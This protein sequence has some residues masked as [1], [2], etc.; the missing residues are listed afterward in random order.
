M[1]LFAFP[2]FGQEL[3]IWNKSAADEVRNRE[4]AIMQANNL[5]FEGD[6]FFQ[7]G[8]KGAAVKAYRQA[9]SLIPPGPRS[10]G[11]RDATT[12]RFAEAATGQAADL[13]KA[14]QQ[15][16]ARSLVTEVLDPSIAPTNKT[17]KKLRE[18]LGDIEF[19]N[20]LDDEAHK[21]AVGKVSRLLQEGHDYLSIGNYDMATLRFSE[22]LGLDRTNTAARKGL[23]LTAKQMAAYQDA[24]YDQ[25]RA[26]AMRGVAEGWATPDPNRRAPNLSRPDDGGLLSS[27]TGS[28]SISRKL[29]TITIPEFSVVNVTIRDVVNLMTQNALEY[30]P[31]GRGIN[32]V[33]SNEGAFDALGGI[34]LQLK[35]VPL[36]EILR[37]VTNH[38]QAKSLVETAAVRIIPVADDQTSVISRQFTVPADFFSAAPLPGLGDGGDDPFGSGGDDGIQFQRV[39]PVEFLKQNGIPFPEGSSALF[40]PS[41][42]TLLVTNTLPHLTLVEQLVDSYRRSAPKM[43]SIDVTVIEISQ[44]NLNELGFDWL[45]GPFE[46]SSRRGLEIA[47]AGTGVEGADFPI[48]A[49]TG[50]AFGGNSVTN[51]LRSGTS[52][53]SRDGVSSILEGNRG[54]TAVGPSPGI[55]A[56]TGTLT[57]PQ[58][59]VVLRALSQK[60]G[61]DLMV[62]P[63]VVAKSNQSARVEVVRE[64]PYPTEYDPP[65]LPQTVGSTD[66]GGGFPVTPAN[67][68]AFTTR[69]VGLTLQVD[70]V[71]GPDNFTVDL[72]LTPEF[73]RFEGFVNYGSPITTAVP[74]A[75]GEV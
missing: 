39:D 32:F 49:D 56:A 69:N 68:T 40:N 12:Q 23:G 35:A 30:D 44:E 6:Q 55:F 31:E 9:L 11:F 36:S 62:K 2:A 7:E 46:M 54:N 29:S 66:G 58:F 21:A 38:F 51:G 33:L 47:G 13:M 41:N 43:A 60:K 25:T 34:T 53:L 37:Y 24:A 42:S 22:V 74:L 26:T 28:P 61:V 17:A 71:I 48:Q 57:D 64:F 19:T 20:P 50:G 14:G 52:V 45:I 16:E 65:E 3:P 72:N 67:P 4:L 5:L 1:S 15:A 63:N 70:P 75:T 18:Q 27:G 73:V 8:N 59:Q 10:E